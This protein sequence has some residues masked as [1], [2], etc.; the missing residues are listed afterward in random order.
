MFSI[1]VGYT[2][3]W[4]WTILCKFK[5]YKKKLYFFHIT[6]FFLLSESQKFERCLSKMNKNIVTQENE[7]ASSILE[8][9]KMIKAEWSGWSFSFL[10]CY[11][12][13]CESYQSTI[14]LITF[15]RSLHLVV[16]NLSKLFLSDISWYGQVVY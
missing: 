9:S 5:F 14:T 16:L 6:F 3:D 11:E 8:K 15:M 1:L 7:I 10:P 4:Y 12:E 13:N 2:N